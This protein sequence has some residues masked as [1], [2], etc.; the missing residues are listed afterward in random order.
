L[1]QTIVASIF[2]RLVAISTIKAHH[3][4]PT[5]QW[6]AYDLVLQAREHMQRLDLATAE[7]LTQRAVELDPHFARAHATQARIY[8]DRFFDDCELKVLQEALTSAQKALSLDENDGFCHCIIGAV[9]IYMCKFDLADFHLGKAVA[10]NP[11]N[12]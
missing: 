12:T 10:L 3:R 9:W 5:K 2:G 6:N 7:L 11:N 8:L 4:P 1:T